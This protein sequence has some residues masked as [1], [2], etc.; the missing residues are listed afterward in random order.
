MKSNGM[1]AF[2]VPL[3]PANPAIDRAAITLSVT[4]MFRICFFIVYSI[5]FLRQPRFRFAA[6]VNW[7]RKASFVSPS[8]D[9]LLLRIRQISRQRPRPNPSLMEI[10]PNYL[11]VDGLF[12]RGLSWEYRRAV[13]ATAVTLSDRVARLSEQIFFGTV[14]APRATAARLPYRSAAR[15]LARV[16]KSEVEDESQ[17]GRPHRAVERTGHHVDGGNVDRSWFVELYCGRRSVA[18]AAAL[19]DYGR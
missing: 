15:L 14:T 8:D 9:C 19:P 1:F 12:L 3:N 5:R 2:R 13:S 11:R 6:C 7:L 16:C 17:I 18:F 10:C 4:T